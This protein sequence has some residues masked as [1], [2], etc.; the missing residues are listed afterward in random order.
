MVQAIR[1]LLGEQDAISHQDRNLLIRTTAATLAEVQALVAQLDQPPARLLIEVQQPITGSRQHQQLLHASER[2]PQRT[3]KTYRTADHDAAIT[4]QRLQILEGHSAAIHAGRLVP[5]AS[6]TTDAQGRTRPVIEH[7]PISSGFQ[8]SPHL[9]GDEV[10]IDVATFAAAL[11]AEG[12]SIQQ[13][14]LISSVR[15]PLMQWVEIA[16]HAEQANDTQTIRR[17][18]HDRGGEERSIFIRIQRI[19]D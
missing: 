5:M 14:A 15:V 13:Q 7:K 9:I 2:Q 11:T 1:P 4:S 18:S 6:L 8:I 19:S 17:N 12:G 16:G 3:P 10:R